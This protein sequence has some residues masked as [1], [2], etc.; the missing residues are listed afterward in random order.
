VWQTE[1][2][3]FH[4]RRWDFQLRRVIRAAK[5]SEEITSYEITQGRTHKCALATRN[6]VVRLNNPLNAQLSILHF[7]NGD[8]H[9]KYNALLFL[10][11]R[12]AFF[13]VSRYIP[14]IQ[15]K[16]SNIQV[17]ISSVNLNI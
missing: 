1:P 4:S 2:L 16:I 9:F 13:N 10:M 17:K 12:F 5:Q 11:Q 3:R 14:D 8:K 7:P 6:D 15:V